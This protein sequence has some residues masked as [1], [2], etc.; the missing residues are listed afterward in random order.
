MT[1]QMPKGAASG[2]ILRT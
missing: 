1:L 2:S